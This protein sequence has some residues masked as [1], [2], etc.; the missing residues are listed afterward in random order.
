MTLNVDELARHQTID[1]TTYG[2]KTGLPRRI[3]IW[4]FLVE[5]R[6]IITGTPGRR[7]WLANIRSNSDVV[8]HVGGDD[9]AAMATE[10][11][12]PT[13]RRTVF[14]QPNTSWYTTQADLDRLVDTAPMIEIH[15]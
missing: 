6:L 1:F 15:L 2:A 14:T 7:D 10:V 9:V 13:F 8:V 3:E 12:D 5:G 11:T 4:W